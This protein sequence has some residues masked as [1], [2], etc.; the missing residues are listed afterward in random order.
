MVEHF[1][2]RKNGKNSYALEKILKLEKYGENW[3]FNYKAVKMTWNTSMKFFWDVENLV[4]ILEKLQESQE[5]I[6]RKYF[7]TC[8]KIIRNIKKKCIL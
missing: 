2:N 4:K 3:C 7:E 8:I 5:K 6:L 1:L